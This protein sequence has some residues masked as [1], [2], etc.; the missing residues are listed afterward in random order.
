MQRFWKC[1]NLDHLKLI[2]TF[3][4]SL[5]KQADKGSFSFF[6]LFDSLP[7]TFVCHPASLDDC[8]CLLEHLWFAEL[9]AVSDVLDVRIA[10]SRNGAV[11][12]TVDLLV[13][14]C[15]AHNILIP[16]SVNMRN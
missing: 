14:Q 4:V 10:L 2:Y 7:T 15:I 1:L 9:S 8:M 11:L 3:F 6:F 13:F 12:S 5:H 16:D